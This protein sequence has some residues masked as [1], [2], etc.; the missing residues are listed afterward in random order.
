MFWK[1]IMLAM[2]AWAVAMYFA[3]T[4]GGLIHL[5]PA[6]AL[7]VVVIRQVGKEPDSAFGRWRAPRVRSYRR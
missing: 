5:V 3:V 2:L 7:V 6:A 1:L 4:V